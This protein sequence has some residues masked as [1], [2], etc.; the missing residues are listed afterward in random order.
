[1][2]SVTVGKRKFL[3]RPGGTRSRGGN[4][5]PLGDQ[6]SVGRDAQ[7]G[8]MMEAAPT[9]PFEVTEPDL[10]LQFLIIA[11]DTPAQFGDAHHFA[12]GNVL[13]KRREPVFGGFLLA[14]GPLDQQPL[15]RPR[16]GESVVSMRGTNAHAG[17][18]RRQ[19]LA[20]AL[21]PRDLA[22]SARGCPE[23]C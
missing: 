12:E 20:A 8:V 22:P 13:R 3:E 23:E 4:R 17:E 6:E 7:C 21:A 10:L 5:L 9:S 15:F 19:P 14:F 11:L 18:A 2:G 1:S 16:L